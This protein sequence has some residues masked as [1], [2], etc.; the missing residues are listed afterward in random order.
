MGHSYYTLHTCWTYDTLRRCRNNT[1][2]SV[3]DNAA[4]VI[5]DNDVVSQ[6]QSC[7]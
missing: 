1:V 7:V 6:V 3:G 5:D 2:C 4:D